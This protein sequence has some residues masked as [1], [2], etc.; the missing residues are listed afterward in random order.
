MANSED[1]LSL[2]DLVEHQSLRKQIATA[3]YKCFQKIVKESHHKTRTIG[4]KQ[5]E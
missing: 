5:K 2:N 3:Q 4:D 1:N